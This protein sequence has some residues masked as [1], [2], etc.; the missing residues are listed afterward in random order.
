MDSYIASILADNMK[1]AHTLMAKAN[2]YVEMCSLLIDCDDYRKVDACFAWI[3]HSNKTPQEII[4]EV[5]GE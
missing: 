1:H 5:F 2:R 3:E 4:K